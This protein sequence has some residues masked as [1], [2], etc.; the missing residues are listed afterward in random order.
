MRL[1]ADAARLLHEEGRSEDE[2]REYLLRWAL[3][4]DELIEHALR[5]VMDPMSRG[6]MNCYPEGR[7]RCHGYVGG[8]VGRFR[9]L[10]TEQVRVRDLTAG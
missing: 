2:V 4:D 3:A 7:S 10:L 8:D 1:G 6:Y 9:T 5:F